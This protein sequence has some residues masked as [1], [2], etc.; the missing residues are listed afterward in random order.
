MLRLDLDWAFEAIQNLD[1]TF[2][3]LGHPRHLKNF[4]TLFQRYPDMRV[5][6]DHAMKPAIASGAFDDWA[7]GIERLATETGAFC[8]LSGLVTE[9]AADW[10]PDQLKPYIAHIIKVFGARRI[11]WGSDWPVLN[12]ASDYSRWLG[13]ADALVTE[14]CEDEASRTAIFGGTAK[15]FYR[16]G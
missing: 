10:S 9:A 3:A 1:L 6:I 7:E 12:L 16:L 5:V 15:R 2:D 13:A 4:L 8:K 14:I 11:M